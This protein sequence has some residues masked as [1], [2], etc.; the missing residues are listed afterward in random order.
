MDAGRDSHYNRAVK[1]E[2]RELRPEERSK[3]ELVMSAVFGPDDSSM[4][5][6]GG[7][8]DPWRD[9]EHL[10][11][12]LVDGMVVSVV[13]LMRRTA[14][15]RGGQWSF[16]AIAGVSTLKEFR[17]RGYSSRLMRLAADTI[18]ADGLDFGLL[19]TDINPFYQKLGWFDV[20]RTSLAVSILRPV[21]AELSAHVGEGIPWQT[22]APIYEAFNTGRPFAVVR[23]PEYWEGWAEAWFRGATRLL[24]RDGSQPV[25]YAIAHPRPEMVVLE[26]VGWMPDRPDAP[27][28]L[29]DQILALARSWAKTRIEGED[30]TFG[31]DLTRYLQRT[32]VEVTEAANR[33]LMAMPSAKPLDELKAHCRL[34]EEGGGA[35]WAGDGF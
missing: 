23:A 26:E 14:Y 8:R 34:L 30:V 2:L 6:P 22:L 28:E 17:G 29:A 1:E 12:C 27:R 33:Y 18:R 24:V 21:D 35:F 7:H 4:N 5:A 13:H 16:G 11:G 19:G 25:A 15:V 31:L 10:F 20:P 32:G 9:Q 3:A